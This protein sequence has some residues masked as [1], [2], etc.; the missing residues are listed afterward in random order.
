MIRTE[1]SVSYAKIIISDLFLRRRHAIRYLLLDR[2]LNLRKDR[3]IT[4]LKNVALGED[5]YADHF[6]GYPVMPGALQ[7]EAFAQAGT[8][9]L[10]VSSGHTKKA[11]LL[12]VEN[13]KFRGVVRPGDQLTISMDVLSSDSRSAK[14]EGT[15]RTAEQLVATARIVFAL[16]DPERYYPRPS[17]H[18]IEAIYGIWLDGAVLEGFDDSARSPRSQQEGGRDGD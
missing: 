5:V 4:A 10:E 2:I 18:M 13:A 6:F 7:I 12:M 8:A 11:L 15:I 16:E 9:L 3:S 14:M 1:V 17:R